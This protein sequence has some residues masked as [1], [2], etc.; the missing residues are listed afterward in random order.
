MKPADQGMMCFAVRKRSA[1]ITFIRNTSA[2]LDVRTVSIAD[3]GMLQRT[4]STAMA[5]F[6]NTPA[7]PADAI[8]NSIIRASHSTPCSCSHASSS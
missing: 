8:L 6:A 5:C 1:T 2:M 4:S 3:F 7:P